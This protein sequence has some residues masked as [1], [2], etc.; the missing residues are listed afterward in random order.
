MGGK[1][2]SQELPERAFK[3]CAAVDY[4]CGAALAAGTR[5]VVLGGDLH[6]VAIVQEGVGQ[7]G[8]GDDAAV[9]V[10][11]GLLDVY[12]GAFQEFLEVDAFSLAPGF[13]G[14]GSDVCEVDAN[15]SHG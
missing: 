6:F 9:Q 13:R 14:G 7:L 15:T 10:Y 3:V 4:L 5:R 11:C 12:L 1:R 8:S 2:L